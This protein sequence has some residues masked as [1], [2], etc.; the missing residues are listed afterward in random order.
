MGCHDWFD[1][2][3]FPNAWWVRKVKARLPAKGWPK[4]KSGCQP[5]VTVLA[6]AKPGVS[7][8]PYD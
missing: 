7:H 3:S 6:F 8:A 5:E 1:S 2:A 4:V